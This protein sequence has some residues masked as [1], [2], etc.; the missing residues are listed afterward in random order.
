MDEVTC[1]GK[2]NGTK[3]D[4]LVVYTAL[5]GA[6][7]DLID[8]AEKF[9]G[10]DFV[11]F[12]DQKHL[13]SDVWEVRFVEDCD[14]SPSMMNRRYKILT[15]LFFPEYESSLYVD[16][17][18]AILNNPYE[19][20]EKYLC[21]TDFALPKHFARNCLFDEAMVLLRSGRVKPLDVFKQMMTYKNEGYACQNSLGENNILFRRH[22]NLVDV[23]DAWWQD[24]QYFSKRDQLSLMF[25]LWK[26][27]TNV[28][29]IVESSRCGGYFLLKNHKFSPSP[30]KFKVYLYFIVFAVPYW[31]FKTTYLNRN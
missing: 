18:I 6:Y 24:L 23:M 1:M 4:R 13:K 28:V 10:C 3:K 11:C 9:V 7:D 19:L 17:N 12:T 29:L 30:I 31:V 16:A 8:P 15:H 5:F 22:N 21:D 20:K 2:I 14:L 26:F 25:V 27:K